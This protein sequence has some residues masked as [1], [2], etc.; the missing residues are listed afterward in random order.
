CDSNILVYAH[1]P[2]AGEKQDIALGL[3]TRLWETM[4]GVLS[5]QVL[6][7]TYLSLLKKPQPPVPPSEARAII[8][9]FLLWQ[10]VAQNPT[11]VL[12]AVDTSLRWRISFWDA[13]VIV[14]ARKAGA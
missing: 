14:A 3:I 13:M 4:D 9:D 5:I 8:E 7:E 12:S 6:Q 11:D 10:T 2:S 1:D